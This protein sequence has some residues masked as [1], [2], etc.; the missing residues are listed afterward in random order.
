MTPHERAKRLMDRT[1]GMTFS[2]GDGKY[3]SMLANEI[4]EAVAEERNA[5]KQLAVHGEDC[6]G[7]HCNCNQ[8]A[9]EIGKRGDTK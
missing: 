9:E 7:G 5:C 6:Y 1:N 8:I 3:A 2:E 4:R